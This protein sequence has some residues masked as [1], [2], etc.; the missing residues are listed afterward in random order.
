MV[1]K[2]VETSLNATSH[3]QRLYAM[4]FKILAII[5]T[6]LLFFFF[7]FAPLISLVW[8]GKVEPFFV[9]SIYTLIVGW[10][11]N[12]LSVPAYISNMG[13]GQLRQN[14]IQHIATASFNLAFGVIGGYFL[15]GYGVVSAW[16]LSLII[17]S[18][19]LI[20]LFHQKNHLSLSILRFEGDRNFFISLL[21][22]IVAAC[23]SNYFLAESSTTWV[24]VFVCYSLIY[25]G[26][27]V[28]IFKNTPLLLE[29]RLRFANFLFK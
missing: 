8:I 1:P 6:P 24:L 17:S 16:S 21:I 5:S 9:L 26:W 28:W 14:I 20:Y 10:Y 27:L 19:I 22:L 2:I 13:I 23:F 15:A 3:F 11:I 29:M 4:M 18:G 7:F 12:T 25:A